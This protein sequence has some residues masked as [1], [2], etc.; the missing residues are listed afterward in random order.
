[1]VGPQQHHHDESLFVYDDGRHLRHTLK[2][3]E[4]ARQIRTKLAQNGRE[5]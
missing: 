1:M 5:G 4:Q 3:L 2:E